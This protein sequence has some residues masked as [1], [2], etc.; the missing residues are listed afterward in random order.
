MSQ[1]DVAALMAARGKRRERGT[2]GAGGSKAG[3]SVHWA[4]ASNWA[5]GCMVQCYGEMAARGGGV[6]EG[7]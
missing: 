3:A 1:S 4:R 5:A 7:Q 6:T 2:A